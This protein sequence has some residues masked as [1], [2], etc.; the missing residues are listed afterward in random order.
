MELKKLQ[1]GSDIRGIGSESEMGSIN[2]T[3]EAVSLIAG[4]FAKWLKDKTNKQNLK[5]AVGRDSRLSGPRIADA[6]T[7]CPFKKRRR[8]LL[9]GAC[10]YAGNVHDDGNPGVFIRWSDHD[11]RFAFAVE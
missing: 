9:F 2:L 10:L 5:I 8:C 11:Y 1:N 7:D 4:A 6:V 3:D